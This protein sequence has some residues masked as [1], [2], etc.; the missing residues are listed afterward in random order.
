[1]RLPQLDHTT[2]SGDQK[3]LYEDMKAGIAANFAGFTAIDERGDL[4]G[5][6]NPWLSF[7]QFGGPVW[8]LVKALANNPKLPKPIREI[9]ILVTGAHFH[10][11]YELYA[12]IL[13]AELRGLSDA[14]IRT[15]TSGNRPADLS[16]E[17]GLAYDFAFALVSGGIVPELLYA[18]MVSTFGQDGTAEFTYL[19]GLYC[20]VS[21]TLNA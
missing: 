11:A 20:M 4:I 2:L 12:H 21:T 16:A 8:D 7:P 19:V 13:V 3:A 1:M 9:G 6:W 5:P 15:I 10:S 18:E 14:K 17:E